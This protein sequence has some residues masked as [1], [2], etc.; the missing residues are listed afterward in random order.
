MSTLTVYDA[1][2]NE[3]SPTGDATGTNQRIKEMALASM[4][5][6]IKPDSRQVTGYFRAKETPNSRAE[7]FYGE[8]TDRNT[9]EPLTD[10]VNA[11]RT[12]IDEWNH[13]LEES[14]DSMAVFNALTNQRRATVPGSEKDIRILEELADDREVTAVGVSGANEAVGLLQEFVDQH[15]VAIADS[16]NTDALS[17]FDIVIVTGRHQGIEP[18][19]QTT[20]RWKEAKQSL[21]RELVD[22]EI[23]SITESVRTLKRDFG[24][25]SGEIQRKVSGL[26]SPSSGGGGRSQLSGSAST[27]EKLKQTLMSPQVGKYLF[28]G[29][30]ILIVLI[31]GLWG[32]G[33][34]LGVGPLAESNEISGTV[35]NADGEPAQAA[36]V[37]I[38]NEDNGNVSLVN[39]NQGRTE[40]DSDGRYRFELEEG[41]GNYTIT[42]ST[43]TTDY[44][45]KTGITPTATQVDFGEPA[46]SGANQSSNSGSGLFS[47]LPFIG[48]GDSSSD[49]NNNSADS[50]TTNN[51]T[52]SDTGGNTSNGGSGSDSGNQE[53]VFQVLNG[54]VIDG[55]GDPVSFANVTIEYEDGEKLTTEQETGQNGQYRYENVPYEGD[56]QNI[57]LVWRASEEGYIQEDTE[58]LDLGQFL[59]NEE[60][61]ISRD[62]QLTQES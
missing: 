7:Q 31:G 40:T 32:A 14:D 28:V 26:D 62:I 23:S 49:E 29:A 9:A 36:I 6:A 45:P 4:R 2:G 8:Y 54:T 50:E 3:Y 57:T 43:E 56:I 53:Q 15:S 35:Y 20:G 59:N 22:E 21:K 47:S 5:V 13:T 12:Q 16:T 44:D 60:E 61:G 46:Q 1:Q 52:T 51:D 24:L 39:R 58:S 11:V 48:G 33:T 30:I 37:Q 41:G 38:E 10:F 18:L 55:N 34:F 19:G 25:S 42:A 27:G 17:E